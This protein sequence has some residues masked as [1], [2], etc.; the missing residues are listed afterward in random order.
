MA[1]TG[2]RRALVTGAG[3][4]VGSHLVEALL[5]EGYQVRGFVRYTSSAR[6][7]WLETLA[8]VS[9]QAIDVVAG[10]LR[11]AEAVRR[12]C[13][14]V[15]TVF[16]L[17]ALV[18]IPY[19]YAHLREVVETNVIGTLNV[20]V[21]AR[22]HGVSR[23][24]YV[25]TS[26]VYGGARYAPMDEAHPLSARSPYAAT[27]LGGEKLAES[28]HAAF[29]L[30]VVVLRPFNMYGPRQSARAVIPTIV[31]QA[32]AGSEIRLGNTATTRDFTFVEDTVA[33]FIRAARADDAVGRTLNVGSGS[34][35]SIGDLVA[36]IRRLAGADGV[37]VLADPGRHRPQASEVTR[38][39]ADSR[40]AERVLGWRPGVG[41]E[42]G[43]RRT[44]EWIR[45]NLAAYRVGRYE[46]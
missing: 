28:F 16:H 13:E 6:A 5:H 1:G 45:Q 23:M 14:G 38:L 30:P 8:P 29:G 32:L 22:D 46:V 3:G 17:G 10:D 42:E 9:R 4:F 33:A 7:G 31:T 24:I 25:S 44:I 19:S 21:A 18:G 43:L 36:T 35:I 39:I 40:L 2:T 41:L 15:D 11:D 20:L 34:E 37:P 12:A 26:E 27:K